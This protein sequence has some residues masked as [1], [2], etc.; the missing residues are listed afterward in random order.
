MNKFDNEQLTKLSTHIIKIL[1]FKI[2][3]IFGNKR[4][5]ELTNHLKHSLFLFRKRKKSD[6][7][8]VFD[9]PRRSHE[10]VQ[11]P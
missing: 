6:C 5:T 2:N 3:S 9:V 1:K 11:F 7:T 8:P 4:K 10:T